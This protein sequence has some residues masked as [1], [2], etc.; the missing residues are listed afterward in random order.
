[1]SRIAKSSNSLNSSTK[2]T[3]PT[4]ASSH[5]P[6]STRQS[7]RTRLT[8][9]SSLTRPPSR[10]NQPQTHSRSTTSAKRVPEPKLSQ[11]SH[12]S[13]F[14]SKTS[15]TEAT[16]GPINSQHPGA[17]IKVVVRCR[18]LTELER[19]QQVVLFTGGVRGRELTV[20]VNNQPT[21]GAGDATGSNDANC[22]PDDP[23]PLDTGYGSSLV[24]DPKKNANTKTYPFDHVFGP[25]ADQS[26]IFNDVVSPILTEVLQGYNCTIFAYGQTG[27]GKTYTMTGDLSI[28]T[29]T[30]IMPTI[31]SSE[32]SSS[33]M[34]PDGLQNLSPT[35]DPTPL[36]IPTSLTKYSTE[37]GIIPRVLHSLF[38]LLEDCSEEEKVEFSVKVSFVELY[39]EELRDLNYIGTDS[40]TNT[41][42]NTG[43][44]NTNGAPPIGSTNLKIF[45]DGT[46][47]KKGG[48]SGGS[49]VY[50]QNLTEAP[51]SSAKE[52]IKILTLG[53]ARRQI[54]AT[55]CNEQSSRSHS[56]FS[57]TIH[58]KDTNGKEG[59]EDQLKIG[60]LNLVDLAGSE[61]VGRSGAGKEFGR[62]REAGMINQSLLT[63]GRVINALVE[64]SSHVPYRES[65]LTRL[66]QDSLGGKTK[67]CI[68]ATVS[69]ARMNIEETLS[70]LD[71]ALRAKS[72][73]NR[74]ELNNKI[75]KA[76]LIN[77]YVHEIEKL[78]H[79]LIATRT[80]NGIYFNEE[81]W[82]E[83]VNESEGK[84]RMMIE[85]RR[86]IELIELELMRTKKEFEKCLRMLNVR[87]GEIKK[88]QDELNKRLN[89]LDELKSIRDHLETDLVQ[90]K[91]AREV[92]ERSRSKWKGR[93]Q[94]AYE[95]N[96]G[97]RAKIGRKAAVEALNQDTIK[98]VDQS[99]KATSSKLQTELDGFKVNFN[100]LHKTMQDRLTKFGQK[101]SEEIS[102]SHTHL[103]E[104]LEGL[105]QCHTKAAE[106]IEDLEG[107]GQDLIGD[108]LLRKMIGEELLKAHSDH[109]NEVNARESVRLNGLQSMIEEIKEEALNYSDRMW[110]CAE[111]TV[112]VIRKK[113]IEDRKGLI[114]SHEE[115]KRE[116]LEQ[117]DL[118]K[119]Q[120]EKLQEDYRK[121]EEQGYLDTEELMR[122]ISRQR[123]SNLK[124]KLKET[125]SI[126]QSLEDLSQRQDH[127]RRRIDEFQEGFDLAHNRL[128]V[129]LSTELDGTRVTVQGFDE[130]LKQ[131]AKA[132][133]K[134]LVTDHDQALEASQV[135]FE[136][137]DQ[138][139]TEMKTT[140][141]QL[142]DEFEQRGEKL[143]SSLTRMLNETKESYGTLR[144]KMKTVED[145]VEDVVEESKKELNVQCNST[146]E[147]IEKSINLMAN[148]Q[149]DVHTYLTKEIKQ[150]VVTGQTPRAKR[151]VPEE[152]EEEEEEEDNENE[153]KGNEEEE[154]GEGER[155][156]M[157]GMKNMS[158]ACKRKRS[159]SGSSGN[160]HS[161]GGKHRIHIGILRDKANQSLSRK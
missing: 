15:H 1:M 46:S 138:I 31:K 30:T 11:S 39:N 10:V 76:A 126:V 23:V 41:N 72:I 17:N 40:E 56:V 94:E 55:K 32:G 85:S 80:K 60:K 29:T 103:E 20:N 84:N 70:T 91:G 119:Q 117:T 66:L 45:E 108:R 123:E 105:T 137:V 133:S 140:C 114:Q 58:V 144:S 2:P 87:E 3:Q 120:I 89:E 73:K 141:N 82:S 97:L 63:L 157:L 143:E 130:N 49:G 136:G 34:N 24:E 12:H 79:D 149:Q 16:D 38:N 98:V 132:A 110:G 155:L 9:T 6:S 36:I 62:A 7:T 151:V 106:M 135:Y 115:E 5:P 150:D 121:E 148:I 96:E 48:G 158:S 44:S 145:A 90:E 18:G 127:K 104:R 154:E 156:T 124:R 153:V 14:D 68:I 101:H 86:K 69:P 21:G 54:A 42:N 125:E 113:F 142:L 122:I 100:Q 65:K 61:N 118:L 146:N 83:M 107:T 161:H 57:I 4:T 51:I 26:L 109:L 22:P 28:P 112:E 13:N 81:R 74:P 77:Q 53:S 33:P 19:D 99:M 35:S 27:T 159:I 67:T 160:G 43:N 71:Y 59:K 128:E 134:A 8:S 37:A 50:I 147:C 129:Q 95:E 111:K 102:A 75:N 88:I 25:D 52:G 93:C 131:K 47:N 139:E 152:E 116:L 92:S 64:K 78:R